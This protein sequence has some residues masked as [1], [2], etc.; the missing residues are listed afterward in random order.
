MSSNKEF[1]KAANRLMNQLTIEKKGLF[2]VSRMVKQNG[3]RVAHTCYIITLHTHLIFANELYLKALEAYVR[4]DAPKNRKEGM[5]QFSQWHGILDLF[6]DIVELQLL[7]DNKFTQLT[8]RE[9]AED[10][11]IAWK[12]FKEEQLKFGK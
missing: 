12:I 2:R 1:E 6:E 11:K 8:K 5:S 10:R 4:L 9:K 3:V 7:L